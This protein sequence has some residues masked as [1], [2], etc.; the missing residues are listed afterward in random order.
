[1]NLALGLFLA[2]LG[3]G[4]PPEV[5]QGGDVQLVQGLVRQLLHGAEAADEFVASGV[6][7]QLVVQA[8]KAPG[9]GGD[10]FSPITSDI[11]L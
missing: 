6:K 4:L 9:L 1:M 8:Q 10:S 11:S 2:L 5:L 3:L 7:G